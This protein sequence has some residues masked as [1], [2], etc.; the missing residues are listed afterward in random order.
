MTGLLFL[1]MT[2][3]LLAVDLTAIRS[4]P[5]LERRAHLALEH[6]TESFEEAKSAYA[7]GNVDKAGSELLDMQNAVE[8]AH[9]ALN[10]T[11]KNPRRHVHP[12]KQAETETHALL[13]RIEGLENSMDVE[14]RK[15]IEGPR[16]KVQEVHDEWLTDIISGRH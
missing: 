10:E 12:F 6:A 16:A 9:V 3:S 7:A 8:I 2:A 4:E 14:D 1:T 5:N 15:L 11:G 13:R